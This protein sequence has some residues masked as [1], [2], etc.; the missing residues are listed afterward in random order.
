ML[1]FLVWFPKKVCTENLVATHPTPLGV[2]KKGS[3]VAQV[4]LKLD[5]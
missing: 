5:V 1:S 3:H 4:V 2:L